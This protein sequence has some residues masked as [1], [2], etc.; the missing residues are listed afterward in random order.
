MQLTLHYDSGWDSNY[1]IY[2]TLK[3]Q[4]ERDKITGYTNIG[5]HKAEL[6]VMYHQKPAQQVLSRGQLKLLVCA[7]KL[8]QGVLLQQDTGKSTL[9]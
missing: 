1:L 2:R 3:I 5:P 6:R 7:L 9:L 8:A 4:Y